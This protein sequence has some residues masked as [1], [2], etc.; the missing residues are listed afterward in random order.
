VELLTIQFEIIDAVARI[1][2]NRPQ[3]A[4]AINEAMLCELDQALAQAERNAD[5]R[6]VIVR[7]AGKCFSSGFDLKEQMER[8]PSG[9]GQWRAILRRD[10]DTVMRFWHCPKP[11]ACDLT[12][13]SDNA[14]FGEPELKF[15]AGIV[16]MI[17]PW[18]A[19]AKAAKEIILTGAD[20]VSAMRARELG[21]INSIV[22]A[23]ELDAAAMRLARHIATIDPGLVKQTKRAINRA[24]EAQGMLDA[25]EAAL[26]ID[27]DI[28]S[29]GSPD[30]VQ[31]MEVARREGLKGALA[32]RDARFRKLT[33]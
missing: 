11:L 6:A 8:R 19:G 21:M 23:H 27:L 33:T 2:L 5:V 15:G 9:V 30:K 14:F 29:Q 3:R 7:G 32:W 28:E 17:L 4:N 1:T 25:L 12:S 26:E 10:F 16:V 31:F 18:M 20:R 22:P 13:A 24:L